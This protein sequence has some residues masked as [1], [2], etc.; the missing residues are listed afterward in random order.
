MFIGVLRIT[1]DIDEAYNLKERRNV[2]R[3]LKDKISARFNAAV[4]ELEEGEAVYNRAQIGIATVSNEYKHADSQVQ[5][6][7]AFIEKHGEYVLFD[8][9]EEVISV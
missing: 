2:V 1:L 6:I 8:V 3:S 4:A 7:L 9:E 5:Q